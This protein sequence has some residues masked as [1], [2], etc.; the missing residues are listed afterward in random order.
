MSPC[1]ELT[2][3]EFVFKINRFPPDS[4]LPNIEPTDLDNQSGFIHLSTGQQI[5]QTCDRFFSNVDVVYIIKFRYSK[6]ESAMKWEPASDTSELFPHYY[7]TLRTADID[8]ICK[9]ERKDESWIKI[10]NGNLWLT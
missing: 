1:E 3:G 4:T 10:R 6:L 9:F 8:S 5:P 2:D 7:G